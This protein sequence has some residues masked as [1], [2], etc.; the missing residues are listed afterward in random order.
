METHTHPTHTTYQ[1]DSRPWT[2]FKTWG[3][4]H[5]RSL[6]FVDDNRLVLDLISRTFAKLGTSCR[7]A[8][9]HDEAV[10]ILEEDP[11]VRITIVDFEMPDGDVAALIRRLRDVRPEIVLVGTSG[12]DCRRHF[13]ERGVDRFIPKPWR[14]GDLIEVSAS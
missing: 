9:S 14:L 5:G 10:G 2:D 7:T 8:A 4:V 1:P 12:G 11:A 6:L 13:V 3:H